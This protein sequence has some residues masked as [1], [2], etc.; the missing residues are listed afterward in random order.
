I[1]DVVGPGA[2]L[3]EFL[4]EGGALHSGSAQVL[5][6]EQLA[7]LP[8]ECVRGLL[9]RN[10]LSAAKLIEALSRALAMSGRKIDDLALNYAQGR[11]ARLLLQLAAGQPRNGDEGVRI[12]WRRR[13]LAEM[14]G[15]STETAIRLLAKLKKRGAIRPAG[16]EL[17]LC[18][19]ALLS[20]LAGHDAIQ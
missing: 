8:R 16:R 15:V 10:P 20:R 7:Y 9:H 4:I 14:I 11:S 2:I 17:I 6:E 18:D 19:Q 1:V 12:Q 13:D 3:G 5:T